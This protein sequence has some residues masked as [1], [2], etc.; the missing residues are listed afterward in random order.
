M[1]YKVLIV[2]DISEPGKALLLDNGYEVKISSDTSIDTLKRD[3]AD[4]DA[5]LS[6]TVLLT[7]E[8]LKSAKN[9][10]VIGKH[11]AGVD[12]VV[13]VDD[14]TNLGI[15]VVNTPYANC[16]SVAE[17]TLG[18]IVALAKNFIP[19]H[20]AMEKGDFQVGE[21]LQSSELSEKTLG[22]IGLGKIGNLVAQ[23]SHYGLEMN[24]IAYDPYVSRKEVPDYIRLVDNIDEICQQSDFISLHLP[25]TK[26]SI[27][28]IDYRKF[29]MMKTGAY[30]INCARGNIVN[31]ADLILALKNKVIAGAAL[32]VYKEEPP[33]LDN[34]LLTMPNVIHTAH[35]AAL[36]KEALDRMSHGA[37]M[38]IHEVL[39]GKKPTW[40]VNSPLLKKALR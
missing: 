39:S 6:K 20:A 9:L 10:K 37:A 26:E 30:F 7:S 11:G 35:S 24:I 40:V 23:K 29:K 34:P 8:V 19:V 16:K 22:L 33:R 15:Y 27:N 28:L 25:S 13:N 2:E 21:R 5:V 3:I 38:G 36:S 32:D 14:A 17:Y 31:E 1:A 18:F 4:C 12:N